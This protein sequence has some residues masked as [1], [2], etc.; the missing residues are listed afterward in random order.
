MRTKESGFIA[1]ISVVIIVALL[2][3]I[4]FALSTSGFF[5]RANVSDSEAK[6]HSVA[7][8]EACVENARIKLAADPAYAGGE[9]MTIGGDQC[10]ITSVT[11]GASRIIRTTA[12]FQSTVTTL[13]VAVSATTL[14]VLSWEEN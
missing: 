14:Q 4:S 6:E 2:M 7:L 10:T 1:I 3:A 5:A 12:T 8:A 11:G 13:R 9:T